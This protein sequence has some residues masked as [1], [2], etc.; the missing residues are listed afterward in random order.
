M[1]VI[2]KMEDKIVE[3]LLT[4]GNLKKVK[5]TGWLLKGIKMPESVAEHS[6]RVAVMAMVLS[7]GTDLNQPKLLKMA[8]LHDLAESLTSDIVWEHGKF[9]DMEKHKTK[10]RRELESAKEITSGIDGGDDYF[11]LMEEFA[12]LGSKE[13]KFLKEIDKLE[14]AVQALEY[15]NSAE[16]S[17]DEFWEN[18]EKYLKNE[19]LIK[20][21]MALKSMKDRKE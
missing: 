14:M 15:K 9:S 1:L 12:N 3:F 6:Y 18:V 17:L 16:S 21:F 10:Y 11:K 13:A 7:K 2:L 20:V 8:L 5:R 4:V 19:K